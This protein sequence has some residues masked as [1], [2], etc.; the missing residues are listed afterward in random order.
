[1]LLTHGVGPVRTYCLGA[2]LLDLK[3]P[4][5]VIG[6]LKNPLLVPLESERNGYVPNVVYTCGAII[7]NDYLV[8]P[9][10]VSDSQSC[11]AK[12]KLDDVL[13]CMETV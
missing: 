8:I 11:I 5:K 10:A 12:V 3:N 6:A 2:L 13:N 9:Y 1:M 4:A 7:H